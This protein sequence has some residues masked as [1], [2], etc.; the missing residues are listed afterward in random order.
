MVR[1][2]DPQQ[3]PV[4]TENLLSQS[5]ILDLLSSFEENASRHSFLL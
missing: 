3:K 1:I 4:R 2:V 5:H